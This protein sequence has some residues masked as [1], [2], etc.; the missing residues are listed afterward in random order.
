MRGFLGDLRLGLRIL[1]RNPGFAAVAILLLAL[2]IGA[3][4][5]IFSVV[6]A[7]LL[8]PLPYQDPSRIMQI[9]HVPPAKSFPGMTTFSVSPANYLDW[10]QQSHSFEEMAAYGGANFNVGGQERPEAIQAARVAPEFFSIL[11]VRPILGR[12]FTPDEDR[13]GHGHVVVL[14]NALWR[15]RLGADPAAVGQSIILDG[16]T[17]TIVGVM[18]P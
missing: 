6:N 4:T 12:T 1:F 9:W 16:E 18:A 15:D 3:N 10:R 2:G 7:V 17:Y 13:P 8:R 5:A 11:R 14:G